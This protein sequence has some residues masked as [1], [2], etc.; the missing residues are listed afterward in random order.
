[1]ERMLRYHS[2]QSPIAL[3]FIVRSACIKR[4]IMQAIL[5]FERRKLMR[6]RLEED[7]SSVQGWLLI[8]I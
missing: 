4:M 1:M 5:E 2:V 8:D 7:Q 3:A 6:S